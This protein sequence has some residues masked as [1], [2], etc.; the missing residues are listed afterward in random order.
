M[1]FTVSFQISDET[2]NKC[3]GRTLTQRELTD[4]FNIVS[5][6]DFSNYF[7][8]CPGVASAVAQT[9]GDCVAENFNQFVPLDEEGNPTEADLHELHLENEGD[10]DGFEL[11]DWAHGQPIEVRPITINKWSGVSYPSRDKR[12][13]AEEFRKETNALVE[14]AVEGVPYGDWASIPLQTL[15]KY[16]KEHEFD[17]HTLRTFESYPTEFKPMVRRHAEVC[18]ETNFLM[19]P[20]EFKDSDYL[21]NHEFPD[22][23][24]AT[25][26]INKPRVMVYD[27]S[28]LSDIARA[29]KVEYKSCIGRGSTAQNILEAIEKAVVVIDESP[30]NADV[31]RIVAQMAGLVSA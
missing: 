11:A 23:T 10:H 22:G 1:P 24:H 14:K 3:F 9:L 15:H 5:D 7:A 19:S 20:Q 4:L 2:L 13:K 30:L 8:G 28:V 21:F 29:H 16:L 31:G 26:R 12:L 27:L 18:R 17:G 6:E 25:L